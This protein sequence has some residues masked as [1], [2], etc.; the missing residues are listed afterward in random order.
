MPRA[1]YEELL[2]AGVHFGHLTRK[3]H[4][5]M[6]PYVFMERQGIHV[7]DLNKTVVKLEEASNALKQIAKSGRKILFVSTKKQAKPLVEQ[8]V[9]PLN[10]PYVTERWPG[11]MLTNFHTIRKSIKKMSQLDKMSKDGTFAS[12]AKRE[13]LHIMRQKGKL[14]KNLAS[15]ADMTRLPAAI[16]VVDIRREHIALAE[17]R[18][19]NIPT[20]AIVDTNSN[21]ELVDFPIPAND[22]AVSSVSY[23]LS[24][25]TNAVNEGLTERREE[26]D[27]ETAAREK[28]KEKKA[29]AAPSGQQAPV[30]KDQNEEP[31]DKTQKEEPEKT[32]ET[33]AAGEKG[34]KNEN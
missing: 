19:L 3:W 33:I 16:F 13:R 28:E 17:A 6:A 15:I 24:V 25:V 20:F 34:D 18:K 29:E 8:S 11:G 21:P 14:E 30:S 22:D 1:T 26:R 4:P 27:A 2:S 5:N 23:I 32:I 9:K 12:V 10:M 7:I 31:G